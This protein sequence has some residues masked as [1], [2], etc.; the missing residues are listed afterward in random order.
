VA[1]GA[2]IRT[3]NSYFCIHVLIV[4]SRLKLNYTFYSIPPCALVTG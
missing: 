1:K 2:P 4:A 3:V